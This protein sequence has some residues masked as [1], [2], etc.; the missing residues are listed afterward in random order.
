M[1]VRDVDPS[2]AFL[3]ARKLKFDTGEDQWVVGN[4]RSGPR[5]AGSAQRE[6]TPL[7]RV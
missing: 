2:R 7:P 6:V 4:P 1:T 5:T 3:R